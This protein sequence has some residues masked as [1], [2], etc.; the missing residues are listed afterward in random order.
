MSLTGFLASL[1]AG[2]VAGWLLAFVLGRLVRSRPHPRPTVLGWSALVVGLAAAGALGLGYLGGA[3][4]GPL[5]TGALEPRAL[6]ANPLA[7]SVA[8]AA[9]GLGL[10]F[11]GAGRAGD[12]HWPTGVGLL[13][14][15]GVVLAWLVLLLARLGA[16]VV[17]R[18]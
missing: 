6:L 8:L 9:A 15:G 18:G 4:G 13:L 7:W 11:R 14:S 2:S 3:L 10:G 5:A 16:Y 12:R 1:L 17:S